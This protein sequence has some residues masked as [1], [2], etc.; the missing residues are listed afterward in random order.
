MEDK[1]HMYTV[2]EGYFGQLQER[3]SGIPRRQAAVTTWMRVR[4][5]VAL[6]ASFLVM[7]T[8][9]T[10]ILRKTQP[11]ADVF[12][13]EEWLTDANPYAVAAILADSETPAPTTE[14]VVQYLIDSGINVAYYETD[15]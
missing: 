13:M 1:K 4:P 7:V 15:D 14:E 6:A 3:L 10:W 12:Q 2:P 11:A 9:G 8:A 5:Y